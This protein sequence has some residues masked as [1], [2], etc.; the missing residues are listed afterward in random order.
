[1]IMQEPIFFDI[2]KKLKNTKIRAG[3]IITP[4]GMIETPAFV[5][6]GTKGTVKSLS[7]D[8]SPTSSSRRTL[9]VRVLAKRAKARYGIR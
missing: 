2:E 3:K 7:A 9:A 8:D 1:M 6:V 5:A 4:R